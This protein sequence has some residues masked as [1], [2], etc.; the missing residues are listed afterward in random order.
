MRTYRQWLRRGVSCALVALAASLSFGAGAGFSNTKGDHCITA[1]GDDLNQFYGVSETIVA[2][3]CA[4]LRTGEH[5]TTTSRWFMATSFEQVPP[6]FVPAGATPLDDFRA[7]FVAVRYVID[8]GTR[9]ERTYVFPNTDELWT[10]V[11][12]G[13]PTVNPLTLGT[14]HPLSEGQHV[15]DRY[16]RFSGLHCDGLAANIDENCLPAGDSFFGR[17]TFDVVSASQT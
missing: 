1:G 8:S 16:W 15:I 7:K 11:V 9:Q 2:T 10:G 13:L 12:D 4:Q 6:G 17:V 3:F 5:W 14:L